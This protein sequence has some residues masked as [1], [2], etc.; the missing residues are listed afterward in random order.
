MN[1]LSAFE[2]TPVEV[3]DQLWR[4]LYICINCN[5][6]NGYTQEWDKLIVLGLT[7]ARLEAKFML[8]FFR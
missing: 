1:E 8:G 6:A 7:D 3:E 2:Y 5:E 4:G